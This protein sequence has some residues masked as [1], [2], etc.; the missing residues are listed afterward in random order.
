[1]SGT[2]HHEVNSYPHAAQIYDHLVGQI[3]FSLSLRLCPRPFTK[4]AYR[5]IAKIVKFWRV[6][7]W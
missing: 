7:C 6:L 2:P 1:M 4:E 5:S 3:I